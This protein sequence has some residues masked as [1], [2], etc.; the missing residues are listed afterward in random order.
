M[1]VTEQ[2][3]GV[4]QVVPDVLQPPRPQLQPP[5]PHL[6]PLPQPPPQQQQLWQAGSQPGLSA[7][8]GGGGG[9]PPEG[10]VLQLGAPGWTTAA[11]GASTWRALLV[12]PAPAPAASAGGAT[13]AKF[14]SGAQF[15]AP[16][17]A[18]GGS[19]LGLA[20]PPRPVP[21]HARSFS[22]QRA[23]DGGLKEPSSPPVPPQPQHA[24]G[25][26]GVSV[27]APRP[28][29]ASLPQPRSLLVQ[30]PGVPASLPI[31]PPC[32]SVSQP[33]WTAPPLPSVAATFPPPANQMAAWP[34]TAPTSTGVQPDPT[35]PAAPTRGTPAPVAPSPPAAD[36][37]LLESL[38]E[39]VFED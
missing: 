19:L 16:P 35:A 33:A 22:A 24:E 30:P 3:L 15:A 10:T 5:R 18:R 20:R 23:E 31:T 11:A 36:P 38:L 27:A 21:S 39:D 1:E 34:P 7:G 29:H 37:D 8:H 12:A 6:Q 32:P 25:G 9:D 26:R 4:Q 14:A 2:W 17:Q 13:A 28:Q